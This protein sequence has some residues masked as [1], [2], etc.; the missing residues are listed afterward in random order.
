M[1]QTRWVMIG[2]GLA[3]LVGAA[4]GPT[5]ATGGT[6]VVS[7]SS[8]IVGGNQANFGTYV[9]NTGFLPDPATVQVVSGGPLSAAAA[10]GIRSCRGYVTNVPDVIVTFPSMYGFLRFG[11]QG[12]GGD[13]TLVIND[14][15]GNWYCD[16]DSGGGL[17]P[18]VTMPNAVPGQYDIWVGSY[19]ANQSIQATLYI[20]ELSQVAY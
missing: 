14:G 11:V 5:Y 19:R 10:T 13:T 18:M 12:N 2:L 16:D 4:C 17:N 15:V 8:L 3:A 20:T 7:G 9:L 6:V 1:K